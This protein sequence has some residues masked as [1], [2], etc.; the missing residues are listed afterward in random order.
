MDDEPNTIINTSCE[1]LLDLDH[2]IKKIPR[3]RLVILQ[4]NNYFEVD[5]HINC[6]RSVEE[7]SN[8]VKLKKVIWGGELELPKYTRY[9]LI[10]YS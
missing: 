1:H 6:V 9:M 10:G 3:K 4:S 5:E 8:L 2:W 7:F